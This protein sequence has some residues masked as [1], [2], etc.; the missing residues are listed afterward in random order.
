VPIVYTT[1]V[2]SARMQAVVDQIGAN[3]KLEI[4]T[5]GMALVIATVALGATAG[6]VS[7]GVITLSGLPIS[8]LAADATGVAAAARIRTSGDVD[9]ITGLTVGMSGT[10]IVLDNTNVAIGQQVSINAATF[11]HA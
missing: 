4:G 7:N 3:G 9:V 5:T 1:A 8:D 2:K 11:T 6:T 10:D